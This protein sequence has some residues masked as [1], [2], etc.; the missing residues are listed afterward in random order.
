MFIPDKTARTI[1]LNVR[2][3]D[4]LCTPAN[5]PTLPKIKKG[6]LVELV[7]HAND[8]L[9]DEER[10]ILISERNIL[11]LPR[12]SELWARVKDDE[13]TENLQP[14]RIETKVYPVVPGLVVAFSLLDD[15]NLVIRG[16]KGSVLADCKCHIP[17][18]D[19]EAKSVNEAC[20]RISTAFEPSRRSHT[21]N[22]FNC[23]FTKQNGTLRPLAD[24]RKT[25]E[26]EAI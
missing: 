7:I 3:S 14:H 13:V 5:G 6:A 11:L 8:L 21:G 24:L 26:A 16:A 23:V 17:S 4:G 2:I 1:R 25:K 19:F 10:K 20:A 9:D 18:L 22:V 12:G 15:L